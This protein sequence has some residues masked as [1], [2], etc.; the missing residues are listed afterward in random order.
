MVWIFDLSPFP[1]GEKNWRW[2]KPYR[3]ILMFLSL[4]LVIGG[5]S[6]GS[7]KVSSLFFQC[8]ILLY[9]N[10]LHNLSLQIF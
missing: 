9:S 2:K 10:H 4:K 5:A 6:D 8:Y 3:A 1:L 7:I